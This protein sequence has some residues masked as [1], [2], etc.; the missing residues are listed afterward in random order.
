MSNYFYG[1][2]VACPK[3]GSLYEKDEHWKRLCLQCWLDE[4]GATRRPAVEA[5][6]RIVYRDRIV[7]KEVPAPIPADM[8]RRLIQLVHP[9]KHAGSESANIATQYLLKL[10]A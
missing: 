10:R 2:M 4:K 6:E 7:Y 1:Q 9:D 5:Q 8:L 3:C